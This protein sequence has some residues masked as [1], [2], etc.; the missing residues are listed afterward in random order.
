MSMLPRVM[1][2]MIAMAICAM[3]IGASAPTA[4][5]ESWIGTNRGLGDDVQTN[6][7]SIYE[8]PGQPLRTVG[9]YNNFELYPGGHHE[10]FLAWNTYT[11]EGAPLRAWTTTGFFY[12]MCHFEGT[13][14]IRQK[15]PAYPPGSQRTV[16]D[17]GN[18]QYH[19]A[20]LPTG[21]WLEN[22]QVLIEGWTQPTG[23]ATIPEDTFVIW[24][25][26]ANYVDW[27]WLVFYDIND[28]ALDASDVRFPSL[29]GQ[30]GTWMARNYSEQ[31]DFFE[32]QADSMDDLRGMLY[33]WA[34][35]M[36]FSLSQIN[37][38]LADV[39]AWQYW[40]GVPA[41]YQWRSDAL[42]AAEEALDKVDALARMTQ[43]DFKSHSKAEM[44][45]LARE[46]CDYYFAAHYYLVAHQWIGY[47][48]SETYP[49]NESAD[50]GA[51]AAKYAAKAYAL[52]VQLEQTRTNPNDPNAGAVLFFSGIMAIVASI[53]THRH[54]HRYIIL[55]IALLAAGIWLL[56]AA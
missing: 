5:A 21:Y 47:H 8:G 37:R 40:T 1:G 41:E 16:K 43:Y 11:S 4:S 9:P 35:K 7:V 55:G 53:I 19:S 32:G 36:Y 31:L 10:V 42:S 20:S 45:A 17:L 29:A 56:G 48:T 39:E 12:E 30:M 3:M 24:L 28:R 34:Y 27:R 22:V 18:A 15:S 23:G 44:M 25:P 2:T 38:M 14:I 6:G 26:I 46:A 50:Y 51:E 13:E 54:R 52:I 33:P 49:N